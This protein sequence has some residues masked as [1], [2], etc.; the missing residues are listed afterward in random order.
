LVLVGRAAYTLQG[1]LA[2]NERQRIGRLHQNAQRVL[3]PL[4]VTIPWAERLKFR[5]D[6]TRMRRDHAKYL[7]LIAAITLLHQHQRPRKMLPATSK[8]VK[9]SSESRDQR[10]QAISA[11]AVARTGGRPCRLGEGEVAYLEATPE[12]AALANRLMSQVMGHPMGIRSASDA[13]QKSRQAVM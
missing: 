5:H 9:P 7:A 3:E 6:Q 8:S 11:R 13:P 12:D 2:E 1:Q 4:P 10:E